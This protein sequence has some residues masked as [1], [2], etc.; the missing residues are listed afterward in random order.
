MRWTLLLPLAA[1]F[2]A[3]ST[4][5]ISGGPERNLVDVKTL[6][7]TIVVEARYYAAHNFMGRRVNGYEADKCL[8]MRQAAE[9]LVRAQ[10]EL[11]T[12]GLGV[13]AYDCYRP[14]RAVA[15][16]AAWARDV[17]DTKMKAEFYP[18]VDKARLF[19]LGYIAERSG[20]SRGST[21]DLT[22]IPLPPP[23]QDLYREGDVL[24]RCTAV[25]GERFRDNSLDMGTGYDCFSELSHTANARVGA[26]PQRNRLLLKS[27]MEKHGFVNYAQ[28]WW[29]FTLDDEPYP[30]RYFD[31]AVR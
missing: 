13:K 29:H 17:S 8:L 30:D 2:A 9:A 14:Q 7:S 25:A 21:I 6:D 26:L 28:E 3:C 15:D 11:R 23:V 4:L 16:F 31:V 27:V 20:H 18:D 22:L 10:A 1:T 12:F 5:G 19:E 24:V